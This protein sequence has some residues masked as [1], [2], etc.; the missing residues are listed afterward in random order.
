MPK[1]GPFYHEL[2]AQSVA[3]LIDIATSVASLLL[4]C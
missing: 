4:S 2:A 3:A 1:H